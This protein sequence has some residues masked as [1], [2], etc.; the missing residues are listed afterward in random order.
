MVSRQDVADLILHLL[1]E[2]SHVGESVVIS[3]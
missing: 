3:G 2:R 1:T